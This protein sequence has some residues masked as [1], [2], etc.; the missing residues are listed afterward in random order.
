[1]AIAAFAGPAGAAMAGDVYARLQ[2]LD[3][4][5]VS[6]NDVREVLAFALAPRIVAI[7]GSFDLVT[8]DSFSRFLVAM[9]YPAER[10]RNPADGAWSYA[11]STPSAALAGMLAWH[12]EHD[13]MMP[14]LIGYSGGG[15]LALRTLHEL[16]GAFGERIAVVD[17]QTGDAL[18]RDTIVDPIDGR[19]RPVVGL[20]VPYAAA[21]ATGKM[22]R[23]VLGQWTMLDKIRS[24]PD[25]VG[26]FT[27][28]TIEWDP[29]AGTF[30]GSEPYAATGSASV[31]NV[32]LP[33]SYHHLDLPRTEDLAADAATRAWIEDYTP[34]ESPPPAGGTVATTNLLHAADIWHSVKKHWCLEGKRVAAAASAR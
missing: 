12:Y 5:R 24:V 8:M 22:P 13:G 29:I 11:S 1:M 9:G 21:L 19:Q 2:A 4:N 27:G 32:T 30:P 15:M 6:A 25:T 26:E 28:F 3:C 33:A 14:M 17:A 31:R 7:S 10:V 16:A 18:P 23:L 34:G 20:R